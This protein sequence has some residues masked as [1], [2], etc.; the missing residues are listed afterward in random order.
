MPTE[1]DARAAMLNLLAARRP[2]KTICPSEVAKWLTSHSNA[3]ARDEAWRSAMPIIHAATDSL[4]AQSLV[5]LS[6]KGEAMPKRSGP[7]RIGRR[8]PE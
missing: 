1:D 6:W 4:V 2:G 7:Y 5:R 8:S 3:T